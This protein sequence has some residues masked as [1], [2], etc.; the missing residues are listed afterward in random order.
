MQRFDHQQ[1]SLNLQTTGHPLTKEPKRP[2]LWLNNHEQSLNINQSQ[3]SPRISPSEEAAMKD[4]KH[5][6]QPGQA[7]RSSMGDLPSLDTPPIDLFFQDANIPNGEASPFAL[8]LKSFSCRQFFPNEEFQ[9][10]QYLGKFEEIK[11]ITNITASTLSSTLKIQN[12]QNFPHSREEDNPQWSKEEEKDYGDQ[13]KDGIFRDEHHDMMAKN[14]CDVAMS[15]EDSQN[16]DQNNTQTQER[17]LQLVFGFSGQKIKLPS[18]KEEWEVEF[19]VSHEGVLT[20]VSQGIFLSVID[21]I[22]LYTNQIVSSYERSLNHIIFKKFKSY[23]TLETFKRQ[24]PQL[25][26]DLRIV[27]ELQFIQSIF[28]PL[29]GFTEENNFVQKI[30]RNFTKHELMRFMRND[31]TRTIYLQFSHYILKMPFDLTYKK[32]ERS[33]TEEDFESQIIKLHDLA[34]LY[35]L[36]DRFSAFD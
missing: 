23:S 31:Q 1:M 34:R 26:A 18:G 9:I 16:N 35:E 28:N 29:V 20:Q 19:T 24:F 36:A 6:T 12:V 11:P 7:V 15:M 22:D 4:H 8:D 14:D 5:S 10:Q 30:M 2:F 32:N 25:A 21:I 27:S 33:Y 17:D 3:L 13:W